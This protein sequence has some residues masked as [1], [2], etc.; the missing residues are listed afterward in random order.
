[1]SPAKIPKI[2]AFKGLIIFCSSRLSINVDDRSELTDNSR[3][4]IIHHHH[5]HHPRRR[6]RRHDQHHPPSSTQSNETT[7]VKRHAIFVVSFMWLS[8]SFLFDYFFIK[9]L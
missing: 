2:Q 8:C 9:K 6:I 4:G 5:H 3:R 1:M 7:V